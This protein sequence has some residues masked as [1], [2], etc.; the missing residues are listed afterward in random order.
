MN[1]ITL[2]LLGLLFIAILLSACMDTQKRETVWQEPPVVPQENNSLTVFCMGDTTDSRMLR[3]ALSRYQELYPNVEVELIEGETKEY[4]E[5]ILADELFSPYEQIAAQIMAGQGPDVFLVNESIMD[6]EKLV[7]QGIF[8]NMEPFFQADHF[9]WEPYHKTIM[10]GGVW[11][12]KRFIIPMSYTFPLLVTSRTALE[13]TGFDIA[14]CKDY[15]GFLDESMRFLNDSAQT[16]Q[17]IRNTSVYAMEVIG[18]SGISITDYDTQTIDLSSPVL[19]P[20]L[21]FRKTVMKKDPKWAYSVAGS[22]WGAAGIRDGE[23]L[24]TTTWVPFDGFF[25]DFAA[26]K[27][28]D[29]PVMM[30]IRDIDGGVQAWIQY[31]VAV[32]ANSKNLQN[33]YNY[34][35]ILLSAE[36]QGMLQNSLSVLNS[37]NDHY[38]QETT[39]GKSWYVLAGT[40]GFISTTNPNEAVDWPTLEEYQQFLDIVQEISGTFFLNRAG[41]YR[42]MAP[43]L[44]GNAG[45]E[46]NLKEAQRKME[47]YISE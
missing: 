29:E 47:I 39:Q 9:D 32:R 25:H 20:A 30:P 2:R 43:Y 34:I 16:R 35:K 46:E 41:L 28:V 44:E 27:T 26:L 6:I 18:L 11:D 23:A 1:K 24:W 17:F 21:E 13:E 33:A 3:S 42:A 10:D 19:Q 22:L 38:Y 5:M 40:N 4:G 8:A 14:A 7:R 12:E 45:Y 31:P 36:I 37:A 15:Q